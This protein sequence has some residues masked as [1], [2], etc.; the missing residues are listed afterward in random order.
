MISKITDKVTSFDPWQ[1]LLLGIVASEVLTLFFSVLFSFIFWGKVSTEVLVIGMIDAF[2][3]ALIIVFFTIAIE[4]RIRITELTNKQLLTEIEERKSTEAKNRKLEKQLRQAQ[5]MEAVGTL[6]GGIAHDFNNILSAILGYSEMARLQLAADDG[7]R[8]DLD[9][10]IKAGH[11]ATDLVQQ[12]L[13]FSRQAEENLQPLKVQFILKE[14]L[15]L[16]RA[17]LP[18]TIQL[19]ASIDTECRLILADPTQIHQVLMNLCTNAKDAIGEEPGSLS[20]LLSERDFTA[21]GSLGG[22]PQIT[23]G[24]YLDLEVSDTGDGMDELTLSKIFD[25]FFTTKEKGK[26]TGLG[27]AVVHGIVNQHKGEITVTSDSIQGTTFHIYLPVIDE[28]WQAPDQ[29]EIEAIPQGKGERILFVD[30][31]QVLSDM[32]QKILEG[33]GYSVRTFAS[34]VDALKAYQQDPDGFDLLIT[35]M[36]MPEMTGVDLSRKLLS[37]RPDLPI[38][39]CSGFSEAIDEKKAKAY[40]IREYLKKP[41]EKHILAKAIRKALNPS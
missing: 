6:A 8:E 5:K 9:Q 38:I 16:L 34:S 36:T 29:E 7:I 25:P 18:T 21:S 13:T 15:R 40:G 4:K 27:L 10:V 12:I 37:L 28:E 1:L 26:G 23:G 35:D 41:V 31:E 2:V 39:L 22:C 14:A 30:D 20:V 24:V 3:V 33:I 11:R 32:M 19:K 17:S